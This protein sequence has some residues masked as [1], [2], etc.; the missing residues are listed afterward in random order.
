MAEQ[1]C[2]TCKHL[3][4]GGFGLMMCLCDDCGLLWARR[5]DLLAPEFASR[6]TELLL[7]QTEASEAKEKPDANA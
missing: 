2:P 6:R 1:P 5:P 4:P 3:H 7:L